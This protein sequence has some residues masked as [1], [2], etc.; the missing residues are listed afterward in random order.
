MVIRIV[1]LTMKLDNADLFKKYFDTVHEIIRSQPGCQ[2]YR[3][4]K[5]FINQIFFLHIASGTKNKT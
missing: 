4:G 3:R 1:K 5:R 2:Q